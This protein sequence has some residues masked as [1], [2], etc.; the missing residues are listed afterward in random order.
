MAFNDDNSD[1]NDKRREKQDWILATVIH[2]D[3]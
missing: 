1:N 3:S 2:S